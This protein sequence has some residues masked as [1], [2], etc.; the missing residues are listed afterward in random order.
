M[1]DSIWIWDEGF[2]TEWYETEQGLEQVSRFQ[3]EESYID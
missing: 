2:W 1:K 3:N